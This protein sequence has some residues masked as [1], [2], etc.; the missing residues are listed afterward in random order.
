MSESQAIAVQQFDEESEDVR[1]ALYRLYDANGELLYVGISDDP[2]GR[3][4]GH[5]SD[6]PWWPDVARK[7]L[8]W[9]A[10]RTQ[11]DTAET[12]A[13]GLER[14]RYNKAKRYVR[15]PEQSFPERAAHRE[16]PA[17]RMPVP[18]TPVTPPDADSDDYYEYRRPDPG[19][20][21]YTDLPEQW[22]A[23]MWVRTWWS[24][25]ESYRDIV[26]MMCDQMSP[27][28]VLRDRKFRLTGWD[29][30]PDLSPLAWAQ[31]VNPH[32]LRRC[33][34]ERPW[35][36]Q[37]SVPD[38]ARGLIAYGESV[39]R[40]FLYALLAARRCDVIRLG[41][42]SQASGFADADE[43]QAVGAIL[44]GMA[45][46]GTRNFATVELAIAAIRAMRRGD[47]RY[48]CPACDSRHVD[49]AYRTPI[50]SRCRVAMTQLT[51]RFDRPS[52]EYVYEFPAGGD[53]R[54]IS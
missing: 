19:R 8:V 50:C 3:M 17:A 5:A 46:G 39:Q 14:P 9:Y 32:A 7:T 20:E 36:A 24:G 44:G 34:Y 23:D 52:G 49:D 15:L 22:P 18:A 21:W 29:D 27:L 53:A 2:H 10:H 33:R 45:W 13:I 12:I 31:P 40:R 37:C 30:G 43:A 6:K 54:E 11:A 25:A 4:S 48:G 28:N 26:R 16:R 41:R 35:S 1:T 42:H 51:R 47:T 38:G